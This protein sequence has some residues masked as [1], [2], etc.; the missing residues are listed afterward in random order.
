MKF[1][2]ERGRVSI[3]AEVEKAGVCITVADT[4]IGMSA[5]EIQCALEPFRQVDNSFTKRFEGT[6]LGLPLARQFAELHGGSLSIESVPGEGTKVLVRLPA[7]RVS[8]DPLE[9]PLRESGSAQARDGARKTSRA[10]DRSNER[11]TL[12]R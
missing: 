9:R 2:P 7:K 10:A 8:L 11:L 5:E 1:T 3:A 12:S 4:G 6:G